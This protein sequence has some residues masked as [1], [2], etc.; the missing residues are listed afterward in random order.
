[1]PFINECL[2]GSHGVVRP[3]LRFCNCGRCSSKCDR[4]AGEHSRITIDCKLKRLASIGM[5]TS[6]NGRTI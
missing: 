3:K 2:S 5:K 6:S 4:N 1:M